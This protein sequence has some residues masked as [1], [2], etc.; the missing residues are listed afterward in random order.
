MQTR[1]LGNSSLELTTIGFGSWAIG[2]GDWSFGWGDQDEREAIDAIIAAVDLGINWIDTAAVYGGGASEALVGQALRELGPSRRPIVATKCGR[3]MRE[4]R[5]IDKVLKRDSIIAECEASLQ[6]LGID[7]IDLY[8]MH[9]PEPDCDIE[10]GWQTLVDLKQQG[11]V[12]E[13]GVSNHSVAQ[14][15]RLQAIHPVASLQPPYSLLTTEIEKEILPYCAEHKVGVV[16]YSPMYKGLLTGKFSLERAANLPQNDHRSRDPRFQ[17]PQIEAHLGLIDCLKP[18]AA[19][20]GRSMAE[21]AIAW[22]LRRPEVTSAIVGARRPS[23][24]A[25]IVK[26]GD[27]V[28]T[29]EELETIEQLRS[30]HQQA[31]RMGF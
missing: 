8:Q 9:W 11:K 31:L 17:P 25:E 3:V 4:D 5:A 26:A 15:A 19:R 12:R 7:C 22:V 14:L 1:R 23:Q 16:C 13:I 18:M 21:L 6:R 10:E 27:W 30:G 24:V 2:G 28:L 20:H 29:D